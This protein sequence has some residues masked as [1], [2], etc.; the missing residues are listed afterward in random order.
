MRIE[1]TKNDML[2]NEEYLKSTYIKSVLRDVFPILGQTS[3]KKDYNNIIEK[4]F[5]MPLNERTESN[6]T[7]IERAPELVMELITGD[8]N[9][10]IR[11]IEQAAFSCSEETIKYKIRVKPYELFEFTKR[12]FFCGI[13]EGRM[14]RI[15]GMIVSRGEIETK[16][17]EVEYE[18]LDCGRI[19]KQIRINDIEPTFFCNVVSDKIGCRSKRARI[20][21]RKEIPFCTLRLQ[22]QSDILSENEMPQLININYELINSIE[23]INIINNTII[24]KTVEVV[25]VVKSKVI[26]KQKI[27]YID[28]NNIYLTDKIKLTEED[29]SKCKKYLLSQ[30]EPLMVISNYICKTTYK[31]DHIKKAVLCAFIN[32]KYDKT[33][34]KPPFHILL[35]GD[36]GIAKTMIVSAF[37]PFLEGSRKVTSASKVGLIG[38]VMRDPFTGKME[39]VHGALSLAHNNCLQV[40]ELNAMDDDCQRAF[41]TT[42]SDGKI[43]IY[44]GGKQVDFDVYVSVIATAN[45]KNDKFSLKEKNFNSQIN[46]PAAL[47]DRFAFIGLMQ[48]GDLSSKEDR[49]E[50]FKFSSSV[51]RGDSY[52]LTDEFV[53]KLILFI[54]EQ[55]NPSV[56]EKMID[57]MN[58]KFLIIE[59]KFLEDLPEK[60]YDDEDLEEMK[61]DKLISIRQKNAV[62]TMAQ[63]I[64]RIKLKKEINEEDI[65]ESINLF[66]EAQWKKIIK[67]KNTLS[68]TPIRTLFAKSESLKVLTHKDKF[69]EV[70]Q[71]IKIATEKD[72]KGIEV[73]DIQKIASEKGISNRDTDEIIDLLYSKGEIYTTLRGYYAYL[74]M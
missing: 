64:A 5:I 16:L 21:Y 73:G 18:C 71:I 22:E 19:K 27:T 46:S 14:I 13:Q 8:F 10:V 66:Y 53:K 30:K 41:Q 37:L 20:R 33:N 11:H 57:K 65:D 28:A 68:D 51:K 15:K 32:L 63:I 36:S 58:E 38:T 61:I 45:P 42:M 3:F 34:F 74:D 56:S 69:Y 1:I 67:Y 9:N 12:D 40:E 60:I 43:S 72:K 48:R 6:L 29:R 2:S 35:V 49:E 44:K 70:K 59:N 25:G 47:T 7:L 52:N 4:V 62:R 24:G 54:R 17:I 26:D 55:P 23:D 50:L 31:L 39:Q